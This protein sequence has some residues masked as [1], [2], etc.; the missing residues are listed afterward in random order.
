MTAVPG[1]A[2]AAPTRGVAEV[3]E[4]V[5]AVVSHHLGD[6]VWVMGEVVAVTHSKAGHLYLT[7]AEGQARLRCTALGRDAL[8]VAGVLRAAHVELVVGVCLRVCGH[9]QVYAPR[10]SVEL[11]V[12]DVDPRVA[13][14]DH[15]LVKRGTRQA[16]ERDGLAARQAGLSLC[17]APLRVGVVAPEGAGLGDLEALLGAS[18][19]AFRLRV[20]RAP[21]EGPTAPERIAASLTLAANGADVVIL[22][23]GGGSAITLPYD[24]EVVVRAVANAPVPVVS[25]LGHASDHCLA[26]EVAWRSVPTPSAAAG[27]VVSMVA[28]AD[29]GTGEL[30]RAIAGAVRA[31]LVGAE[32][33]LERLDGEIT[34]CVALARLASV[35]PPESREVVVAPS[36]DLAWRRAALIALA[37]VVVLLV[38]IVVV[39]VAR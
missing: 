12:I 23:R 19:W 7:L 6:Q 38:L 30:G 8:R 9:L 5:G 27:L 18:G 26:D 36:R 28:E 21:G 34:R 1:S 24:A 17:E 39:V 15:E 31:R 13:M 25:A 33:E 14:G 3:L 37:V 4:L 20:V 22:A 11:R 10:A 2:A 32:R 35:I 16:L 29:R